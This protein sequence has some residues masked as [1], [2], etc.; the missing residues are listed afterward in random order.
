MKPYIVILTLLFGSF[1]NGQDTALFNR[2]DSFVAQVN[3]AAS[4]DMFDTLKSS[5]ENSFPP[6]TTS[7]IFILSKGGVVQ[8]IYIAVT[9]GYDFA[10]FQG[11]KPVFRQVKGPSS[12]WKYYADADTSYL[13]FKEDNRLFTLS[14]ESVYFEYEQYLGLFK[15]QL[16]KNYN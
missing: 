16:K 9:N 4:K 10:I 3:L 11:G 13:Y 2:I 15:D 6:G 7:E 1:V 8:K 12:T 14:S 5:K